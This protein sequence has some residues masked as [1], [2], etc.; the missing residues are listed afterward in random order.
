MDQTQ[1]ENHEV[2]RQNRPSCLVGVV[3]HPA[4]IDVYYSLRSFIIFL[5]LIFC[6]LLAISGIY[7]SYQ[8][9]TP[10]TKSDMATISHLFQLSS[11]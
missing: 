3:R 6:M 5:F 10:T 1:R 9:E 11:M 4:R 8:H 2:Y 7:V